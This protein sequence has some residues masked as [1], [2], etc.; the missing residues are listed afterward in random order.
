MKTGVIIVAGGSG[1]RMG[2]QIPK[3][4]LLLDGRPILIRSIEKFAAAIPDSQ[5]VVVLPASETTR[6]SEICTKFDLNVKHKV[7]CGGENRFESVRAGL[8]ELTDVDL[9]AVHDGVRCLLSTE[10]IRETVRV[11]ETYG[12]AIPVVDAVDSFR[13]VTRDGSEPVDRSVLRAVQ[14][15]QIFDCTLLK[16]AYNRPY[17]ERFTDDASVVESDGVKVT[18]CAGDQANIKITTPLDMIIAESILQ[19]EYG[20][21]I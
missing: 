4:F 10:M 9:V 14:T 7:C 12:T 1:S 20:K 8:G 2:A 6:W 13:R 5:I 3:Q 21:Q 17:C 18:L 16:K 11:A 15:P 19:K